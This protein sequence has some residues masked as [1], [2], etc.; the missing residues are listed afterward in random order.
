MSQKE[1]QMTIT[2]K[3]FT[4][5]F[6]SL[7]KFND[8][9]CFDAFQAELEEKGISLKNWFLQDI[10]I[11]ALFSRQNGLQNYAEL[12]RWMSI[13]GR[14]P[15]DTITRQPDR[16]PTAADMSFVLHDVGSVPFRT[17]FLQLVREAITLRVINPRVL[18]WDGQFIRA[19]SNNNINK[20]KGTYNDPD[21]GYYRH[22]GKKLGVG[23]MPGILYAYCGDR[24][25]P[26][27]FKMSTGSVNYN[28]AFRATLVEF[29]DLKIGQWALVI[30]DAGAYSEASLKLCFSLGLVPIIRGKKNLKSPDIVELKPGYFF[31]RKY[32]PPGWSDAS[33][34]KIFAGRTAIERGNSPNNM[35]FHA[36]RLNTRGKIGAEIQRYIIYSLE[37]LQAITA[38]KIGRPDLIGKFTAFSMIP[39]LMGREGTPQLAIQSG[40]QIL[41]PLV[42]RD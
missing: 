38:F 15:L 16:V 13:I 22:I 12:E 9:S 36:N 8:F 41:D 34:L 32:I 26:I 11:Y 33:I 24:C 14:N 31:N 37:L 21:A 1:W 30:V 27:Y 29:L 42:P 20:E 6:E 39:H 35:V 40:Y 23:Y 28:P 2:L 17:F 19:S 18:I 7:V 10:V 5:F 3:G 25:L 4:G